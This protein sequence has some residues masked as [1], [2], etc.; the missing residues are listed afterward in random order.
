MS[1]HFFMLPSD[2]AKLTKCPAL[3]TARGGAHAARTRRNKGNTKNDGIQSSSQP[4]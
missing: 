3:F 4:I 2:Q 1:T